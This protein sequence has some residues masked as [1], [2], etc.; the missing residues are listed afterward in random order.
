MV[1]LAAEMVW[2]D[3]G[4][5]TDFVAA[6]EFLDRRGRLSFWQRKGWHRGWLGFQRECT[7][8]A[9]AAVVDGGLVRMGDCD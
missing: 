2:M 9:A 7:E 5:A 8:R 6:T 3:V 4:K 1:R